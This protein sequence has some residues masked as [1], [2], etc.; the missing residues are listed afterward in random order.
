M[1][2]AKA[3]LLQIALFKKSADR[4]RKSASDLE[5]HVTSSLKERAQRGKAGEDRFPAA[6][7][8]DGLRG[9]AVVCPR[10]FLILFW[11]GGCCLTQI[12]FQDPNH[13][14]GMQYAW[15]RSQQV[16]DPMK[17]LRCSR[18]AMSRPVKFR[19]VPVDE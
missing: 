9:Y 7:L 11:K 17:R 6:R 12:S 1:Q 16:R 18:I 3:K 10:L 2:K 19:H 14:L 4:F 8:G 5:G 13:D 15:R